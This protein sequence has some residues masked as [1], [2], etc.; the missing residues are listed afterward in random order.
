MY[1]KLKD[2]LHSLKLLFVPVG[3]TVASALSILSDASGRKFS[4]PEKPQR[5]QWHQQRSTGGFAPR[6]E[7]LEAFLKMICRLLPILIHPPRCRGAE[8]ATRYSSG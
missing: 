1:L 6:R 2:I 7:L 4:L 8:A 5:P 3:G